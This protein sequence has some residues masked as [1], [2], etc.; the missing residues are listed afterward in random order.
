MSFSACF[1]WYDVF[2]SVHVSAIFHSFILSL[3][4]IPLH[5]YS[6]IPL[7][8]SLLMNTLC[9][10]HKFSNSSGRFWIWCTC[11]SM[12]LFC[13]VIGSELQCIGASLV[14][15]LVKNLPA[16]CETWVW[17]LGWKEPLEKGKATH[18]SIL[19]YRIP[20]TL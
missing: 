20:W 14:A 10:T 4:N 12:S 15:Q 8:C 3:S 2:S 17:S 6:C 13:D 19:A 5:V 7:L 1:T 9:L 16:V 18:S 11:V